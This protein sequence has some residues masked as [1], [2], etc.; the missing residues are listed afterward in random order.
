[1][2]RGVVRKPSPIFGHPVKELIT[3]ELVRAREKVR[4]SNI[5]ADKGL[6]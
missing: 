5:D 1:M 2:W 6:V 3:V 4:W